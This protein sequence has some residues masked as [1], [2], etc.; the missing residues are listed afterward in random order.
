[1]AKIIKDQKKEVKELRLVG[2][3]GAVRNVTGPQWETWETR[4]LK[5]R[6][7]EGGLWICWESQ[8]MRQL[9]KLFSGKDSLGVVGQYKGGVLRVSKAD[10]RYVLGL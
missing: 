9:E 1:M 8:S 4:Y 6:D 5:L 10:L 2:E 3:S 7:N